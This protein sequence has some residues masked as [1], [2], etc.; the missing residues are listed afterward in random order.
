M[1]NWC[2]NFLTFEGDTTEIVDFFKDLEKQKF[3]L[4]NNDLV[5]IDWVESENIDFQSRWS[6]PDLSG[7]AKQFNLKITVWSEE[8]GASYYGKTIYN[9]DGTSEDFFLDDEDFKKYF[10]DDAGDVYFYNEDYYD[11]ESDILEIIWNNKFN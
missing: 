1:A 6:Q 9:P 2:N 4:I 8:L 11:C 3:P 10:Y 7:L 5:I